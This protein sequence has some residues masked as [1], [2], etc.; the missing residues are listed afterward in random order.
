MMTS[1]T[2]LQLIISIAIMA[3]ATLATRATPFVLFPAGKETPQIIRF[4]GTA[5]PYGCMAMLVVYCF[6]GVDFLGNLYGIP[7]IIASMAVIGMHKWKHNLLLS[8]LG[9]TI[10]YMVMIQLIFR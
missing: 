8:I 10:L 4:L 1:Q 7:E 9:G 5:L 2:T 6:K 3:V